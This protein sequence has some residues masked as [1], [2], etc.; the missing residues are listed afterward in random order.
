MLA[1]ALRCSVVS[2]CDLSLPFLL[3]AAC[4]A[5]GH[6]ASLSVF[7]VVGVT[8]ALAGP[9][10]RGNRVGRSTQRRM[11]TDDIIKTDICL[12]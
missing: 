4:V 3:D 2:V 12:Q 8:C 6:V 5:E 10:S 9:A 11:L 1:S 7:S